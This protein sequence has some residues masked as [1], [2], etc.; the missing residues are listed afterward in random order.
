MSPSLNIVADNHRRSSSDF[1]VLSDEFKP[2]PY[3]AIFVSFKIF[4]LTCFNSSVPL[5]IELW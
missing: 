1:L 3:L 2:Q 4:F 5:T